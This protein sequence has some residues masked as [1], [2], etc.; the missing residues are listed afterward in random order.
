MRP[1]ICEQ[2]NNGVT[3]YPAPPLNHDKY[4]ITN[5]GPKKKNIMNHKYLYILSTMILITWH[6]YAMAGTDILKITDPNVAHQLFTQAINKK[7]IEQLCS[8]YSDDAVII[9]RSGQA[10]RGKEAIRKVFSRMINATEKLTL[11]TVYQIQSENTVLFRSK[12]HSIYNNQEGEKVDHVNS[13]I[14]ILQKQKDGTWLFIIDHHSGGANI[15]TC[16]TP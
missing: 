16:K 13:G 10:I 12:Y 8:I 3:R 4:L 5:I 9:L 14:E 1:D 15:L 11:E 2:E 6:S 7:D